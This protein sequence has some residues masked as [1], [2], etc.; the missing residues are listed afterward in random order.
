VSKKRVQV[1][2]GRGRQ[3]MRQIKPK[4]QAAPQDTASQK[5]QRE[6]YVTSGGLLQG[7]PPEFVMRIGYY[8]VA[9]AVVSLLIMALILLFL[10]YGWPVRVAAAV[11]WLVP[12]VLGASF[13]APAFR[14]AQKDRTKEPRLVQGTLLGA[15]SVSQQLGL[16][17][18]Y[19][20][21]RGGDEQFL[22]APE[23]LTKVPGNQVTVMIN[24]TPGL[25]HVRSVAVVGQRLVPRPEQPV[26]D[27]IRRVRLLP[28]VTPVALAAAVILGDDAVALAP[29]RGDLAHA[30]VALLAGAILGGAVWGASMLLQRRLSA[31]MQDLVQAGQG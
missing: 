24:V 29:I 27:V 22:V 30:V 3:Q 15:S 6:R 20:R 17:M 14:L 25:R 21:T 18:L 28:I 2:Q 13:I 23:R 4:I 11:P 12:I 19:V 16:G 26:P 8:A 31:Q 10:P 1:R 5:K 9:G 7:Y